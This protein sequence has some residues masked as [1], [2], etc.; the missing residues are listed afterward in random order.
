MC[1]LDTFI[2][3]LVAGWWTMKMD[4]V[5]FAPWMQIGLQKSNVWISAGN[6]SNETPPF[7]RR[8]I[9]HAG[10]RPVIDRRVYWRWGWRMKIDAIL[11]CRPRSRRRRATRT[12][13]STIEISF[14]P[15]QSQTFRA[16]YQQLNIV[17][18]KIVV[19]YPQTAE[20]SLDLIVK[21]SPDVGFWPQAPPLWLK[22]WP[23]SVRFTRCRL[24]RLGI[25]AAYSI[26]DNEWAY[27]GGWTG[28]TGS[29]SSTSYRGTSLALFLLSY[30]I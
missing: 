21:R 25:G 2:E 22:Y 4:R 26:I 19:C 12:H 7:P 17:L 6:E 20:Y 5:H 16:P 27:G 9:R 18:S 8:S 3:A 11:P 13:I 14:P 10:R 23:G 29:I 15:H 24:L 30:K 1:S 28:T